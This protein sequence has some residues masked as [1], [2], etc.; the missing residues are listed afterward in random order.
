MNIDN[1]FDIK[2]IFSPDS[3]LFGI[4]NRE[5]ESLKIYQVDDIKNLC[6]QIKEEEYMTDIQIQNEELYNMDAPAVI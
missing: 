2:I 1:T 6:N 3:K 5:D 4:F